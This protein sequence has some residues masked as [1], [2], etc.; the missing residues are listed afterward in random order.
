[1][2]PAFREGSLRS[3]RKEDPANPVPRKDVETLAPGA[4][5]SLHAHESSDLFWAHPPDGFVVPLDVLGPEG[6]A[7]PSV[8]TV[9][10]VFWQRAVGYGV[11]AG[12]VPPV[13]QPEVW[14]SA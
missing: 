6:S 2:A 4:N 13:A 7:T 14:R 5:M 10:F 12:A 3:W 8:S 9:S 1:M 11:V